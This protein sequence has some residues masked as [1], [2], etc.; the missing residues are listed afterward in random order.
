VKLLRTKVWSW[1]D[2]A[3]LK[4]SALLFGVAVGAY[5]ASCVRNYLWGVVLAAVILAIRPTVHYFK[6]GYSLGKKDRTYWGR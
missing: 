2:I 6:D 1:Q 4:W 3:L 5:F